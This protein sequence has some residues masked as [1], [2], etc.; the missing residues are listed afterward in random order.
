MGN[1]QR[2]KR[3]DI[4]VTVVFIPDVNSTQLHKDIEQMSNLI[5]ANYTN[6]EII[7]VENKINTA[8]LAKVT[9]LLKDTACLRIIR[10]S[11]KYS[12]DICVYVGLESAIGD[13]VVIRTPSDPVSLIPRMVKKAQGSELVFGVSSQKIRIGLFNNYGAKLF[14]WY[15]KKFLDISI[16]ANSTYFMA[17]N[18]K[19][20]NALTRSNRSAKHIRYLA[21]Q[22]GYDSE[23]LVYEPIKNYHQ[24]KRHLSQLF[25]SAVELSTNYSKH[26]LRF[27]A[28]IGFSASL[29][30]L[31]YAAYVILVRVTK[32]HVT[33]GWTSLS[34]QTAGMFFLL[35]AILAIMCEYIGK[36]LEESWREPQYH[37]LD[38]LNSE[39]SVADA[40]R[41]NI[42][43]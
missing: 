42:V 33:E 29:M 10:L 43:R 31:G 11:R 3:E 8:E 23:E 2:T 24:E 36:I 26:P 25:M 22:I 39:V 9:K 32:G 27:V 21:R 40:T 1:K 30:N 16:P 18:R 28:W 20:V 17:L 19:A 41:R 15:N 4:F 6:Y 34:L 35:F 13:I 38:E 5:T 14:Y 37:I 7:L 12:K